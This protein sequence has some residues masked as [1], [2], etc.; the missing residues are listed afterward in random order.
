MTEDLADCGIINNSL[1]IPS[2]N[3]GLTISLVLFGLLKYILDFVEAQNKKEEETMENV[4]V[5]EAVE[6]NCQTHVHEFE[7]S[8]KLAEEEEDRH[9]HRF[10][11]VTTQMIP[12]PGGHRHV[13]FTNTDFF[14][15]HHHEIGALSGPPI[16]IDDSG[17]HVHFF[18]GNS[19]ID[20]GH[21]HEFQFA[22][23]IEDPL[24]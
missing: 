24:T 7:G 19:T 14:V 16:F 10:A 1:K 11:G 23:L 3:F 20:D 18:E 15:N 17:K 5:N 21:F 4:E 13:V 6:E 2:I 22:T 8:T 12:F 9:N